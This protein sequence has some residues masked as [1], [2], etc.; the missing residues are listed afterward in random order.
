MR[1][2]GYQLPYILTSDLVQVGLCFS[3]R[4]QL[5]VIRDFN[6]RFFLTGTQPSCVLPVRNQLGC[7]VP[8]NL[9]RPICDYCHILARIVAT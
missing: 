9:S 3:G 1:L 6:F 2:V 5:V 7:R 8:V 4:L